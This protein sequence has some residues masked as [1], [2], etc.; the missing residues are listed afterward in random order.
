MANI[1]FQI[2]CIGEMT[3][4]LLEAD[5]NLNILMIENPLP[6]LVLLLTLPPY[7]VRGLLVGF[8]IGG[9]GVWLGAESKGG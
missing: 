1:S 3:T 5:P 8:D 6:L 4:D 7:Q 9:M 2:C